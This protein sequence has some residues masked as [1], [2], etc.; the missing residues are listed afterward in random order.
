[1]HRSF[2]VVAWLALCANWMVSGG[3]G[4]QRKPVDGMSQGGVAP[5]HETVEC[6]LI[7]VHVLRRH[8]DLM[9]ANFSPLDRTPRKIYVSFPAN[10]LSKKEE[11]LMAHLLAA[12]GPRKEESSADEGERSYWF[13]VIKDCAIRIRVD[14]K[15][16]ADP[17]SWEAVAIG[18]DFT[19]VADPD[20]RYDQLLA[21][22]DRETRPECVGAVRELLGQLLA[23][24]K[25]EDAFARMVAIE[26]LTKYRDR[27][28]VPLLLRAL[29][30]PYFSHELHAVG[31]TGRTEHS[32]RSVAAEA[33]AALWAITDERIGER[34]RTDIPTRDQEGKAAQWRQWW[35]ENGGTFL[36]GTPA[37]PKSGSDGLPDAALLDEALRELRAKC[38][39]RWEKDAHSCFSGLIIRGR[40][41]FVNGKGTFFYNLFP[42]GKS[43]KAGLC[44]VMSIYA[45]WPGGRILGINEHFVVVELPT[46]GGG[47]DDNSRKVGKS[48]DEVL[49]LSS[50]IISLDEYARVLAAAEQ[51]LADA[52]RKRFPDKQLSGKFIAG[53]QG[54]MLS[55]SPDGMVFSWRRL[56]SDESGFRVTVRRDTRGQLSV[57]D[58]VYGL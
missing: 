46:E 51:A 15:G 22:R 45:G 53:G 31:D 10:S 38:I 37:A 26:V 11:S 20:K 21:L 7:S 3:C 40:I 30:D 58:V 1:M 48:L 33:A 6:R 17:E 41:P 14:G 19:F 5:T 34:L 16:R 25:K 44:Q 18:A 12:C 35:K 42:V 50:P 36:K 9:F 2:A 39:G 13:P 55:E 52:H 49:K 28:A 57:L 4:Q 8:V 56:T 27:Q 32:Y 54:P 47:A 29:D 23:D 43:D 24:P